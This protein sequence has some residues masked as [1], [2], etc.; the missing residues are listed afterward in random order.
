MTP[1]VTG[2]TAAVGLAVVDALIANGDA[3]RRFS[4]QHQRMLRLMA[5]RSSA[6]GSSFLTIRSSAAGRS[7]SMK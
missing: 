5:Q 4:R 7:S 2:A 6:N 1:I 3:V